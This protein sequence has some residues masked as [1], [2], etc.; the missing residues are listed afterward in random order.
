MALPVSFYSETIND[1]TVRPN[2]QAE[3]ATW[4][5]PVTTL[6]AADYVAKKTLIDALSAAVAAFYIGN[7]AKTAVT[8]ER[9][10]ESVLPAS[11]PLAQR[12]NK[13]LL[14]YED[15]TTHKKFRVSIPTFDLTTLEPFSEEVDLGSGAGD[16]LK[17]AFEAIVV[18]PDDAAN[19]VLL[20][21]A[22]FVGRN[23]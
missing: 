4:E 9:V 3:S 15:A 12:E 7:L 18:S 8:I 20:T 16:T 1:N 2:G 14:R 23:T 21:S 5:V 19:A 17:R 22:N 10:I 13:L 6:T 11:G